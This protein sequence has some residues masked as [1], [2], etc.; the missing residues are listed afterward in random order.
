MRSI[1]ENDITNIGGAFNYINCECITSIKKGKNKLKVPN[2]FV[3]TG[4][5][6]NTPIDP[7]EAGTYTLSVGDITTNGSL[8]EFLVYITLED[9]TTLSKSLGLNDKVKTFTIES[10]VKRIGFYSQNSWSASQDVTTTFTELML[11]E[12]SEATEY[13]PYIGW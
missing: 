2:P 11:E 9:E 13:E 12:S 8:N 10:A 4:V 6:S 5:I 7:I 1:G 3:V